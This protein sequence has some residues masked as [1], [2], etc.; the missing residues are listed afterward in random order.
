MEKCKPVTPY[1]CTKVEEEE[2]KEVG[3]VTGYF[4]PPFWWKKEEERCET[5]VC[6]PH[7][8]VKETGRY[9]VRW[10]PKAYLGGDAKRDWCKRKKLMNR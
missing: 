2:E 9:D 7:Q 3:G 6:L 4:K 10:Q 8:D 1:R 5:Y